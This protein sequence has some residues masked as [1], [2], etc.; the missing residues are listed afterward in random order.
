MVPAARP[1]FQPTRAPMNAPERIAFLPD[2]QAQ[3][4][5]RELPIDAVGVGGVRYPVTI[6]DG[7][8]LLPTVATLR[9]TVGLPA[10]AKGTHMSRFIE[11]L[12]AQGA[13]LDQAGFKRI[14]LE[15]LERLEA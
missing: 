1:D 8:R 3:A 11:L 5:S 13:A 10:T 4:D 15:M 2:M 14:L 7:G 9:M 6:R 12:E